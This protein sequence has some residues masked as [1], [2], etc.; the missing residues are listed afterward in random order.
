MMRWMRGM[1]VAGVA[2]K[3]VVFGVWWWTAV[4][5]AEKPAKAPEAPAPAADTAGLPAELLD[6]SRGFR[7]LL[8]GVRKRNVALDQREQTLTARETALR[9]LE[10]TLTDEVTR[11]E[12]LNKTVATKTGAVEGGGAATVSKVYESMKAEEA[13]PILDRLD[14]ATVKAILGRMK[15]KQIGAILAAMKPERAVTLTK[16]MAGR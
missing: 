1:V 12:A 15:E 16:S 5:R 9:A 13:A 4:A 8:E 2:L 14:D 3:L 7:D 6:K 10:K 11:L